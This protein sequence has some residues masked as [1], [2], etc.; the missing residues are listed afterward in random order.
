MWWLH[1]ND[2][3]DNNVII[4][5]GT[6][7]GIAEM[8]QPFL[9]NDGEDIEINTEVGYGTDVVIDIVG[10]GLGMDTGGWG[11]PAP[12]VATNKEAAIFFAGWLRGFHAAAS[13]D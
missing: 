12:E 4:T 13:T 2:R 5:D 6:G 8:M 3:K 9:D 1:A 7:T 10:G 11:V